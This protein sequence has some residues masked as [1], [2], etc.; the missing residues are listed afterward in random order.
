M[1]AIDIIHNEHRALAAVLKA[2]EF[3]V[4][5]IQAERLEPDFQL[6]SAMVD[7][8]CQV[9][10]K[11]H[12]PK[13]DDVLFVRIRQ[14][15][16]DAI[17]ILD[18]L[19]L[20]HKHGKE[21]LPTLAFALIHYQAIG[22]SAFGAFAEELDSYLSFNW[23]HLNK[24]ENELIPLVKHQLSPEDWAAIDAEFA[25]N[26]DPWSGAEGEFKGLFSKIVNLTPA[27]LGLG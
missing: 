15:C 10:E 24:E 16:P 11:V 1:K 18:A 22:K 21:K 12:H 14:K 23:V 13:E 17:P 2:M 4:A 7:Y 20:E 27:P 5:E 6:L 3:V 9:P 8:I 26:Q 25:A 19:E